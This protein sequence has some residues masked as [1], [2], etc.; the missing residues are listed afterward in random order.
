MHTPHI[1]IVE[2]ELVTRN[3]LKSIFE[4]EGYDVFEATDGAE[5]HQILSEYD[6]NLVIM[7]IMLP[8]LDGYELTRQLRETHFS[9]PILMVTAK[10][11]PEDKKKGFIVGTDDYMI[12]P[13]D[14]E[15]MIL[16][17]K[18][19][20]RRAQIV[21]EHRITLGPV[22][23]DYDALTVSRGGEV[24]TLPRKE[25]YLLYKLLSYPGKIFTRVQLMDEIWGMES[26]SDDNTINVHVNRLRRRFEGY[27]EF[28]IET[29]RGL[30]YKAVKNL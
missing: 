13:V 6:I 16:R 5:M 20:L 22:V 19:L 7:D 18:A 4:A 10:Q 8:G 2:D 9:L 21:N 28:S 1:L 24:Q 23:L 29:I 11:L 17:I 12:K 30:G 26:E 15:E 3:T 14:E 27:P 25:F